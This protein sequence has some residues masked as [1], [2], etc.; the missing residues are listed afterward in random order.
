[1]G[2]PLAFGNAVEDGSSH[3]QWFLG[4]YV[5]DPAGLRRT[6][7]LEIKWGV[8]P[9]GQG[10]AE[11]ARGGGSRTISILVRGRFRLEF[12]D[13]GDPGRTTRFLLAREGDYL[14]WAPEVEHTWVAEEDSVVVTVRWP[15]PAS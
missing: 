9:A 2:T 3:R 5:D 12:R 14:V 1:M 13:P 11:W 10:R 7:H 6:D 8:H 4:P 15:E